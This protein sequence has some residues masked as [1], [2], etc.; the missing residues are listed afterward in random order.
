M[1]APKKLKAGIADW[2]SAIIKSNRGKFIFSYVPK[3]FCIVTYCPDY[4]SKNERQHDALFDMGRM[5][6]VMQEVLG[7]DVR[8]VAERLVTGDAYSGEVTA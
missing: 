3:R 4:P 2:Q 8:Q 7:L 1:T 5:E 6:W